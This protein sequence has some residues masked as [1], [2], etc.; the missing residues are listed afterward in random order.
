M[1]WTTE[2]SYEVRWAELWL[3]SPTRGA[4]F[5]K[6]LN[7]LKQLEA[8]ADGKVRIATS[9]DQIDAITGAD[10]L[11][12]WP[13]M[14][15]GDGIDA[16]LLELEAMHRLGLRSLD[17]SGVGP[18]FSAMEFPLRGPRSP[19]TGPGL[20]C[21]KGPS[22]GMQ[23]TRRHGRRIPSQ[24]A[25]FLGRGEVKLSP[26]GGNACMRTCDLPFDKEPH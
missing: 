25:G 1:T 13:H 21:R 5:S 8:R 6:Q 11:L 10:R 2:A 18:I 15:G 20:T 9:V 12:L 4:R 26:S 14:E 19:D 7:A 22:Q 3:T 24:R 16:D 17:S 23:P